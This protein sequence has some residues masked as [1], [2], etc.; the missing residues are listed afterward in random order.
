MHNL[1][2]IKEPMR[3]WAGVADEAT[4]NHDTE[5][6]RVDPDYEC[7][8]ESGCACHGVIRGYVV[9]SIGEAKGHYR[10]ADSETLDQIVQ[11]GNLWK[12]GCVNHLTHSMDVFATPLGNCLILGDGALAVIAQSQNYR[13]VGDSVYADAHILKSADTSPK[14]PGM[15][16]WLLQRAQNE[17][18]L[19]GASIDFA[20]DV[21]ATK[22]FIESHQKDGEFVS[23][24]P[25]NTGNLPHLRLK[26]LYATDF[27]GKGA[28]TPGGLFQDQVRDVLSYTL[29]LSDTEPALLQGYGQ[30]MREVGRQLFSTMG[31]KLVT[32][33]PGEQQKLAEDAA[34]TTDADATNELAPAPDTMTIHC[35]RC[36]AEM[37]TMTVNDGYMRGECPN[38]GASVSVSIDD[39]KEKPTVAMMK[40]PACGES[41]GSLEAPSGQFCATC[42]RCGMSVSA[43]RYKYAL[44]ESVE[45]VSGGPVMSVVGLSGETVD[46]AWFADDSTAHQTSFPAVAIRPVPIEVPA[47]LAAISY[48]HAH[49]DGTPCASKDRPWDGPKER[50][51]ATVE[52]LQKMCAIEKAHPGRDLTKGDLK[53]P[54][55]Y[56]D[57]KNTLSPRG[58]HAAAAREPQ[59]QATPAEHAGARKHL[60]LHY[61]RDLNEQPPWSRKASAWQEYE[62]ALAALSAENKLTETETGE[63]TAEA[64]ELVAAA[65]DHC[66]FGD[67]ATSVRLLAPAAPQSALDAITVEDV[68]TALTALRAEAVDKAR[69]EIRKALAWEHG[70]LP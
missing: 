42:P 46:C 4:V 32:A 39:T 37:G 43:G 2:S 63:W 10:Y 64:S 29:G 9:A 44:G 25:R 31:L 61:T 17:P 50:A 38:C 19:I 20:E 66:G 8:P 34:A 62:R 69:D 68:R 7:P 21:E 24:D 56:A 16:T 3:F 35:P 6:V 28:L 67:E 55:H 52:Q 45:L 23:P 11:L 26:A 49:P 14:Y 13:R 18:H 30:A 65:L 53:L 1:V 15:G 51:K 22:A 48:E 47:A 57:G 41:L 59:T 33:E 5:P 54:H 60:G 70:A 27:V 40:C 12:P 36:G 58:V